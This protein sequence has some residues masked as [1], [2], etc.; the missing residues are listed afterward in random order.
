M[1]F[2]RIGETGRTLAEENQ[3]VVGVR[4]GETGS[5]IRPQNSSEIAEWL[6]NQAPSDMDKAAE[7]RAL[8]HG[9]NLEVRLEGRYP[10]G[11]NGEYL[12]SY[13]V[14]VGCNI[15]GTNRDREAAKSDLL[16]FQTPAPIREIEKWLAELSVLTAGRGPDGFSAELLVSAYSSRLAQYPADVARYALLK[17]RWKWFPAW[18]ELERV[19]EAKASPR[20]HMIAALSRPEPD[21]EPTRRPATQ[22]EKDRIAALIAEQFPSVPQAWRDRAAEEATKGN[23]M[24]D[25][26]AE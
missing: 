22:E 24:T 1:T 20:R 14:A 16:K 5:E 8:S 19:C 15:A 17:H 25:K 4:H 7:S 23:C 12:P 3:S 11:E 13:T 18:A 10:T 26:A 21:P 9:V 2:T 6:S